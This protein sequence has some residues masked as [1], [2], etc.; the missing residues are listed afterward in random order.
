MVF[1]LAQA[2]ID[3]VSTVLVADALFTQP[4]IRLTYVNW[5]MSS[6]HGLF[7]ETAELIKIKSSVAK[8]RLNLFHR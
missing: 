8:A 2:G 6:H 5:N 7:I 3:L 4:L 1:G